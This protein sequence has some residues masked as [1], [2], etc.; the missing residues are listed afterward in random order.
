MPQLLHSLKP[1]EKFQYAYLDI[2]K[3]NRGPVCQWFVSCFPV[4]L[5]P[6]VDPADSRLI[7]APYYIT[8][9]PLSCLSVSHRCCRS[10]QTEKYIKHIVTENKEE[11]ASTQKHRVVHRLIK[12]LDGEMDVK[13]IVFSIS[14]CYQDVGASLYIQ[15]VQYVCVYIHFFS[16]INS[17]QWQM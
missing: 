2:S 11:H 17:V 7:C 3:P 8:H 15:Y 13:S 4:L 14:P 9:H 5:P 10:T 12:R 1:R 6:Q 16:F